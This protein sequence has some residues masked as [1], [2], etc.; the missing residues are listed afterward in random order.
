M[1]RG[2]L[3]EGW[4]NVGWGGVSN[5]QP[6]SLIEGPWGAFV[7]CGVQFYWGVSTFVPARWDAQAVGRCGAFVAMVEE[8]WLLPTICTSRASWCSLTM[9]RHPP[10][11]RL[12]LHGH[13][14]PVWVWCGWVWGC[15]WLGF[16]GR[17]GCGR[18]GVGNG[19]NPHHP[20]TV[21]ADD[22][23]QTPK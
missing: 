1:L 12:L 23:Q 20:P 17:S 14:A 18:G 2:Y 16:G 19:G 22:S 21:A 7:V 11:L 6:R 10:P 13:I 5:R 3:G 15:D 9:N 4:G 8:T